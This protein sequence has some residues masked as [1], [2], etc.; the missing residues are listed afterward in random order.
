MRKPDH[1]QT[2]SAPSLNEVTSS[3]HSLSHGSFLS[4]NFPF[5]SFSMFSFY[6]L[7]AKQE[8]YL[9]EFLWAIKKHTKDVDNSFEEEMKSRFYK[10]I[11]KN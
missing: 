11:Q 8:K 1:H 7:N 4:E 5:Q 3:G 6:M 2:P 10:Q 9:E